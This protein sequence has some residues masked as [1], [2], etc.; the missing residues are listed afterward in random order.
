MP[1]NK[2]STEEINR[3]GGSARCLRIIYLAVKYKENRKSPIS[4]LAFATENPKKG[5][6][7]RNLDCK[8]MYSQW[9]RCAQRFFR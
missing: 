8:P 4:V 7:A 5:G 3:N 9:I 2:P 6:D 1:A